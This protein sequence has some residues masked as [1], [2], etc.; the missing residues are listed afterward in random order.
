MDESG[1]DYTSFNRLIWHD[2]P[3]EG[4]NVNGDDGEEEEGA[5]LFN[6]QP[7]HEGHGGWKSW[8]IDWKLLSVIFNKIQREIF[9]HPGNQKSEQIYWELISAMFSGCWQ[10]IDFDPRI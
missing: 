9:S 7:R 2:D 6:A 5:A 3:D 1:K 4:D 10:Q 8:Q